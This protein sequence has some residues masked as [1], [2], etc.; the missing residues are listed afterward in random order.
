VVTV[1]DLEQGRWR[2]NQDL[3]ASLG[4]EPGYGQQ[5]LRH[6]ARRLKESGKYDLT[7]W[8]YHAMLGG[9]GHAL[10]PAVEQAV[11][12]H[13]IA[14]SG[15][16]DFQL[17]GSHPFTEHYSALG[18]EV[19]DD[20]HGQAIGAKNQALLDKLLKF[21]AVVVAGQA[22]SHCVAW[23]VEDLLADTRGRDPA[24]AERVYLLED[25]CSPVVV[26]GAV[27]YTEPAEQ[28]FRRFA[29]AG[30]HRVRSDMPLETWPGSVARE[31][32]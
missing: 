3:S 21:D 9:V 25:C 28:A 5:H 7:I 4:V 22:K 13:S 27:D 18:P 14:R 30:V 20:H 15:R 12:F 1:E 2:F 29:E 11:F 8:P 17:K 31:A 10:V 23:T 16:V 32:A 19:T 6:Y 26:P 24:L